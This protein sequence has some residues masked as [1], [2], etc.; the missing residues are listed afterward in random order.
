MSDKVKEISDV[1]MDSSDS[2]S[3]IHWRLRDEILGRENN[4]V[5]GTYNLND[6]VT[7]LDDNVLVTSEMYLGWFRTNV[8]G[9][10]DT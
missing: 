6:W 7:L 2:L 9:N 5:G 3:T 10:R 4:Q 8:F 1:I